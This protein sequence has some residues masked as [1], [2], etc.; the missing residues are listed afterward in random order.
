ML[1]ICPRQPISVR[2]WTRIWAHI[3]L[4][5]RWSLLWTF[6]C[7]SL[8]HT[9]ISFVTLGTT[10]QCWRWCQCVCGAGMEAQLRFCQAVCSS[11]HLTKGAP[12]LIHS[13]CSWRWATP[14]SPFHVP[15]LSFQTLPGTGLPARTLLTSDRNLHLQ[16]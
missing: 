10:R 7:L 12:W 16:K 6:Y 9:K 1:L 13:K 2:C 5:Q 3:L 4:P 14:R 15:F 8:Y 11:S